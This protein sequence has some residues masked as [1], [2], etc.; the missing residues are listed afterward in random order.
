MMQRTQS[1]VMSLCTNPRSVILITL[2]RVI[3][4]GK[5]GNEAHGVPGEERDRNES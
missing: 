3:I 4:I 2:R 1:K 5:E